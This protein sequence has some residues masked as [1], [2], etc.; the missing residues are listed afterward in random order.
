ME[1]KITNAAVDHRVLQCERLIYMDERV[2]LTAIINIFH[3][4]E[5]DI[6]FIPSS[7]INEIK[8]MKIAFLYAVKVRFLLETE[9][10][11]LRKM[12]KD[13]FEEITESSKWHPTGAIAERLKEMVSILEMQGE[14]LPESLSEEEFIINLVEGE[15]I[16]Y[17]V[18]KI[19][20]PGLAVNIPISVILLSNAIASRLSTK[21][22]EIF[23]NQ[24]STFTQ[25]AFDIKEFQLAD[26]KRLNKSITITMNFAEEIA[27]FF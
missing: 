2:I 24:L 15:E 3:S 25:L 20:L 12:Y 5:S 14:E 4:G 26:L 6:K 19:P 10:L 1:I 9:P 8:L 11:D 27:D 22:L 23:E 21:N 17:V 18:T 16:D 13:L 7:N